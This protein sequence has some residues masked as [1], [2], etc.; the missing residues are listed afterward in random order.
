M[1]ISCKSR[2]ENLNLTNIP[3]ICGEDSIKILYNKT[4]SDVIYNEFSFVFR[5]GIKDTVQV[6]YENQNVKYY[7]D[8]KLN[9]DHNIKYFKFKSNK[10]DFVKVTIGHRNYCFTVND[11]Y[12]FYDF[13]KREKELEI[14]ADEFRNRTFE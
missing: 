7:I 6:K 1:L 5:S 2:F 8:N 11:K 9:M 10:P 13:I 14:Y 4:K 3:N 12:Y